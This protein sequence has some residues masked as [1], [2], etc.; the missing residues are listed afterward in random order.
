VQIIQFCGGFVDGCACI[1]HFRLQPPANRLKLNPDLR[2]S[3]NLGGR[4]GRYVYIF[5]YLTAGAE[6]SWAL[7]LSHGEY[8]SYLS[9]ALPGLDFDLQRR[10]EVVGGDHPVGGEGRDF[11]YPSGV[12]VE[13]Q[14]VVDLHDHVGP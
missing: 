12:G 5:V 10:G 8:T 7:H 14:F 4:I 2:A 1:Y 3:Q 13:D 11:F 6:R 9:P